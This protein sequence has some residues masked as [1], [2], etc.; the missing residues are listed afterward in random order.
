MLCTLQFITYLLVAYVTTKGAIILMEYIL[1]EW[2]WKQYLILSRMR[3]FL[4]TFPHTMVSFSKI[5]P[6][7]TFRQVSS[8]TALWRH[9]CST[10]F[11]NVIKIRLKKWQDS[12][13]PPSLHLFVAR[14]GYAYVLGMFCTSTTV[15]TF[16]SMFSYFFSVYESF[17]LTGIEIN[18]YHYVMND[19]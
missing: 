6:D 14:V 16:A 8:W 12:Q 15:T 7:S 3:I 17:W 10:I 1:F 4:P 11:N 5:L 2:W 18:T 9:E 13:A 19:E